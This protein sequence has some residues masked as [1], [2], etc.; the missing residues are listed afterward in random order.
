MTHQT[1]PKR[2]SDAMRHSK[3]NAIFFVVP[4]GQDN[5]IGGTEYTEGKK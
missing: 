2:W 4:T 5:E 3:E 1:E